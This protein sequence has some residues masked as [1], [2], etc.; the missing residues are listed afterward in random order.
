MGTTIRQPANKIKLMRQRKQ[1]QNILDVQDVTVI[2]AEQLIDAQDLIVTLTED[3]AIKD[4][5]ILD[6][7]D[8]VVTLT[9]QITINGGKA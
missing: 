8:M 4:Q 2:N 3:N 9:E 1:I 7:Q 5:Q 6:L